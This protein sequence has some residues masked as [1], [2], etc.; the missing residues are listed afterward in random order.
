MDAI[1]REY[2]YQPRTDVATRKILLSSAGFVFS[3]AMGMFNDRGLIIYCITL[4][5]PS[6]TIFYWCMA[7]I[8]GIAALSMAII[9]QKRTNLKQRIAFTK[10]A[11]LLPRAETASEEVTVPY[12]ELIRVVVPREFNQARIEHSQGQFTILLDFLPTNAFVEIV[13]RLMDHCPV[14]KKN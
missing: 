9:Y 4:S 7:A 10:T 2:P 13:N 12:A 14:E 6:A 8:C 5:Q 3:A 11:V 1:E